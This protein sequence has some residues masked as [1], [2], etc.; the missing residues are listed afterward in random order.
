[1]RYVVD[2]ESGSVREHT[3]EEKDAESIVDRRFHV[4]MEGNGVESNVSSLGRSSKKDSEVRKRGASLDAAKIVSGR[5]R[6]LEFVSSFRID[7]QQNNQDVLI[8]SAADESTVPTRGDRCR[9]RMAHDLPMSGADPWYVADTERYGRGV[10]AS[11]RLDIGHVV[12]SCPY[13]IDMDDVLGGRFLDFAWDEEGLSVLVLG[14]GS[15]FN[16]SDHPNVDWVFENGF[17]SIDEPASQLIH[18]YTNCFVEKD[19]ELTINYGSEYWE[20]PS[21]KGQKR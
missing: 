19:S 8:D 16:H 9:R 7:E 5:E 2:R 11:K 13:V 12:A 6:G 10:F 1:M 3:G 4:K 14:C 21:R 17:I 15:L 18:F 20:C